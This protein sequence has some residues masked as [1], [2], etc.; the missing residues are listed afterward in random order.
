MYRKSKN[1]LENLIR[2]SATLKINLFRLNLAV[3]YKNS[4]KNFE[5]NSD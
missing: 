2:K 5:L 4:N 3:Y 1:Y